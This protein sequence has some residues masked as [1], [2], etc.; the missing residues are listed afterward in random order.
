MRWMRSESDR[1]KVTAL[2]AAPV[3]PA[4]RGEAAGRAAVIA[5]HDVERGLANLHGDIHH[6]LDAAQVHH[7][8]HVFRL[9]ESR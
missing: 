1:D 5:I 2:D 3:H 8:E 6:V 4:D 9:I 7:G